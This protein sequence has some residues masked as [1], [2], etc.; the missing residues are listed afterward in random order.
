MAAADVAVTAAV[1]VDVADVT[2]P[3]S[4]AEY[5]Q[6]QVSRQAAL[7]ASMPWRSSCAPNKAD[8]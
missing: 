2:D 5:S 7:C 3:D 6:I 8:D 1:A 4:A